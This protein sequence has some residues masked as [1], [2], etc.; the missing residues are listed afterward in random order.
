MEL[1]DYLAAL[2]HQWRVWVGATL[3]GVVL[4]VAVV[5]VA[6]RTYTA[7]ASVFVSVSPS[8]PNSAQF[9]AQRVKSYPDVAVS[10][11]VL[12]AVVDDL[13][14]DLTPAEL[15]DRVEATNPA[16]T[17]Q[18]VV[19]VSDRDPERAA[20]LADAV[21]DRLASVVEDLERPAPGNR[22]VRLTVTDPATV[23]TSP[24]SPVVSNVLVAGLA[25]G[26]FLGLA[27]AA[28]RSRADDRL[29]S[30]G[31]VRAAWGDGDGG[32]AVEVLTRYRRRR[33]GGLTARPADVLAR[34][35]V[36]AAE[37]APVTAVLTS[38]GLA[39]G[40]AAAALADEI[41]AAVEARGTSAAV[42]RAQIPGPRPLSRVQLEVVDPRAPL[43]LWRR[44]A[45]QGQTVV[46][47]VPSGAV[48][49]A[50]LQEM[51]DVLAAGGVRR[52]AVA[53]VPRP[54]RR[55]SSAPRA[56]SGDRPGTDGS[57]ATGVGP[58][59]REPAGALRASR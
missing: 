23:P 42:S 44:A 34:R 22:P 35:L 39:G 26:L 55:R 8:I 53:V 57:T 16:D 51:R 59:G 2:R 36:L 1:H 58:A 50:E 7:S 19:A 5:L 14:L 45:E 38:P 18:V 20:A 17:S 56:T 31:D 49:A 24:S 11:T 32:G 43:R 54:S 4:A 10:E 27:V 9:V 40:P 12:D 41:G 13:G 47:V 37:D 28:L 3:L 33:V 29:H 48:T 6:P 25:L 52:P 15:A 21:A 30:A 46:L